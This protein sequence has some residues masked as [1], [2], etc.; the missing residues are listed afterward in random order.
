MDNFLDDDLSQLCTS[1]NRNRSFLLQQIS[2]RT[3][4]SGMTPRSEKEYSD[5]Q[6]HVGLV[7]VRLNGARGKQM[8]DAPYVRSPSESYVHTSLLYRSFDC[9][10]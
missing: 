6:N 2:E 5:L 4:A 7:W 9:D 10:A 3:N 8:A 1:F